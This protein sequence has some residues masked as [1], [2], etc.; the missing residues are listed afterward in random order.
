MKKLIK[1]FLLLSVGLFV[2]VFLC[3][4]YVKKSTQ[5]SLYDSVDDIPHNTTALVLG[6]SKYLQGGSLNYYFTFRIE[7]AAKL[8]KAGK[9]DYI[10][11]SGDN[12]HQNYNE[13]KDMKQA[14][15]EKGIPADKIYLDYAGL[16]TLDSVYRAFAIFGQKSFTIVSQPFHNERAIF[17]ANN[18]DLQTI[19]YNAQDVTRKFGFKTLIREKFAR[20]KVILDNLFG[21]KPKYLGEQIIIGKDPIV[22]PE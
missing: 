15:I 14:L 18:L 9:V 17:I 3:N 7:A 4:S 19:G 5:E 20:V 2:F 8:F 22:D 10:L 11:V 1:L 6:T 12:S 13:P 16:R 21:K